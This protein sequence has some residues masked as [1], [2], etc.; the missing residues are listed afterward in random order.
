M[1]NPGFIAADIFILV[2]CIVFAVLASNVFPGRVKE[3][4]T[5]RGNT[6]E[7]EAKLSFRR[8]MQAFYVFILVALLHVNFNLF[9]FIGGLS[10][11]LQNLLTVEGTYTSVVL[12]S[13]VAAIVI[14][15]LEYGFRSFHQRKAGDIPVPNLLITLLRWILLSVA[16]TVIVHNHYQ[17]HFVTIAASTALLTAMIGLAIRGAIGDLFSGVAMNSVGSVLPTQWIVLPNPR[18]P[19][20]MISGEVIMT[21]WRETRLRST[22]GHI[23]IIPNS[24][25]AANIFHNMAWPDSTR[26]HIL[27]FFISYENEPEAVIE[28]L[29]EAAA[30][31]ERVLDAPNPPQAFVRSYTEY[32][33]RYILRFWSEV[34]HDKT[35]TEGAVLQAAWHALHKRDIKLPLAQDVLIQ[36]GTTLPP[37]PIP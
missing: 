21:N 5:E 31:H 28:A 16:I 23:Y 9:S 14:S 11:T 33:V 17:L 27:Q 20:S 2:L 7:L 4:S 32:G 6:N 13:A 15:G 10:P 19:D 37:P 18:F 12:F 24:Y 8:L 3:S 26:R 25:L 36:K 34:Y 1:S 29:L 35:T 30:G 22:N